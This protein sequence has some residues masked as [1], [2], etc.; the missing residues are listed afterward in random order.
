[1]KAY[2]LLNF[3]PFLALGV[4]TF[5]AITPVA[6]MYLCWVSMWQFQVTLDG[7]CADTCHIYASITEE[8][9]NVASKILIQTSKGFIR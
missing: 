1:M 5:V 7:L 6:L 2:Y 4:K 8:S 9:R 3:T